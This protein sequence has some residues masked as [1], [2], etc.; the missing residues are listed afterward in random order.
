MEATKLAKLLINEVSGVDDPANEIPGWMVAKSATALAAPADAP[1]EA[2]PTAWEKIRNSI[3]ATR[4]DDIDMTSEELTAALDER[5]N[6][7]VEKFAD[8]VKAAVAPAEGAPEVETTPEAPAAAPAAPAAEA[9]SVEAASLSAEDLTKAIQEA[10]APY[11]EILEKVIDR[12]EPIERALGVAA[13]QSLEGQ[14]GAPE[15]STEKPVTKS[16]ITTLLERP[17]GSSVG[18]VVR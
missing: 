6:A 14:E 13:R 12:F 11:N 10:L 18:S 4:K 5:D 17:V 2:A 8:V 1:S 15:P 9:P 7:L 16:A 3:F